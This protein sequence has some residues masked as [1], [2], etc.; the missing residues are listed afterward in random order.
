MSI[1][2]CIDASRTLFFPRLAN[3]IKT[4]SHTS[5]IITTHCKRAYFDA[6]ASSSGVGSDCCCFVLL[7]WLTARDHRSAASQPNV[8]F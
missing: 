1:S 3:V 2:I 7:A 5:H 4:L 8:V 6:G